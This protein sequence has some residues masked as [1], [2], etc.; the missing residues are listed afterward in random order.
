MENKTKTRRQTPFWNLYI[1]ELKKSIFIPFLIGIIVVYLI[2]LIVTHT[3]F[4]SLV[5]IRQDE[6]EGHG[7]ENTSINLSMPQDSF[8]PNNFDSAYNYAL[9]NAYQEDGTYI[10]KSE[11]DI[12]LALSFSDKAKKEIDQ[13]KKEEGIKFYSYHSS[14]PYYALKVK[15]NTLKAI[16]ANYMNKKIEI[17]SDNGRGIFS[18]FSGGE[19]YYDFYKMASSMLIGLV[20]IYGVVIAARSYSTEFRSGTIK[21][22]MVRPIT[23]NQLTTA[24]LLATVTNV[25]F[26]YVVVSMMTLLTS[27]K[28]GRG[29]NLTLFSF[30]AG[31]FSLVPA[32][33]VVL[34]TLL[35]DYVSL[36]SWTLLSFAISTLSKHLVPGIVAYVFLPIVGTILHFIGLDLVD[37]STNMTWAPFLSGNSGPPAIYSNFFITLAFWSIYVIGSTVLTY[38]IVNKR[39][40]A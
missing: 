18:M 21:M 34:Y 39:D 10:F 7:I 6:Y 8:L 20:I 9:S 38:F 5:D 30:N 35:L 11:A 25:T 14:D 33:T 32:S 22:L 15:V 19:K 2:L 36:L 27:L 1:G 24:K 31:A 28:Y 4:N 40:L 29:G 13:Q 17:S 37:I 3:M 23:R 12:D 16:K 26:V